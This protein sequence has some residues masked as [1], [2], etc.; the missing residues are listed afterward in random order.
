MADYHLVVQAMIAIY[1]S[2]FK[3]QLFA[4][5]E[6]VC[7]NTK[8]N[9]FSNCKLNIFFVSASLME[10]LS[11]LSINFTAEIMLILVFD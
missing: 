8:N 7:L 10:L 1:F 2:C 6:N 11:S 9:M 5:E 4:I 3:V